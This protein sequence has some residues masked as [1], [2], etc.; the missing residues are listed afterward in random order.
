M[1]T[2]TTRCCFCAGLSIEFL[3]SLAK[4]ELRGR[5]TFP[6]QAFYQHQPS[7]DDL[8]ASAK[9]GCD[10]CALILNCFK[11]APTCDDDWTDWPEPWLGDDCA[12]EDS[13]YSLAKAL[14]DSVVRVAISSDNLYLG[15]DHVS[16][17]SVNQTQTA[18]TIARASQLDTLL[19]QVGPKLEESDE[20][21]YRSWDLPALSLT[22]TVPTG[23]SSICHP[24]AS[25]LCLTPSRPHLKCR[26]T[27]YRPLKAGA[28]S[29]GF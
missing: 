13:M 29:F 9:S 3:V 25:S 7:F 2:S 26:R 4:E 1:A 21:Y 24:C 14:E 20:F 5:H 27:H 22:L 28:R 18:A 8:E 15:E 10:L 23:S 6:G 19:I 16:S 12:P 17:A 11:G